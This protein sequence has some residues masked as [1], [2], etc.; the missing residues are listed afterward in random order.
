M[1]AMLLIQLFSM[2]VLSNLR[3][4]AWAHCWAADRACTASVDHFR[5]R[6]CRVVRRCFARAVAP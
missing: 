4:L 3:A 6:E 5:S 1:T 2:P